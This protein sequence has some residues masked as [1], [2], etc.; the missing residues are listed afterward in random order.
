MATFNVVNINDPVDATDALE[1]IDNLREAVATGKIKAFACVGITPNHNTL[2]WSSCTVKTTRLEV[3][4][5]IADLHHQYASG[6][7]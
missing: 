3:L 1:V 7:F 2:G 6:S 4:G 5:A